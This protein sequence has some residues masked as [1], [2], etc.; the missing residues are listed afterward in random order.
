[1]SQHLQSLQ[2]SHSLNS[3]DSQSKKLESFMLQLQLLCQQEPFKEAAKATKE[4]ADMQAKLRQQEDRIH[5]LEKDLQ[6]EREVSDS[7]V[8]ELQT[9]FAKTITES[10]CQEMKTKD[11]Q[12]AEA[13]KDL[14]AAKSQAAKSLENEKSQTA[15]CEKAEAELTDAENRLET[16]RKYLDQAHKEAKD[17]RNKEQDQDNQIQRNKDRIAQL[18]GHIKGLENDNE[19]F[20]QYQSEL[21][22]LQAFSADLVDDD[23]SQV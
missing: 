21:Q 13:R 14:E 8:K 1:M 17:L 22:K 20:K 7:N 16:Q 12:V 2:R 11:R 19:K 23:I 18:E 4:M 10:H 9:Y 5:G 6:N 15:K 3:E